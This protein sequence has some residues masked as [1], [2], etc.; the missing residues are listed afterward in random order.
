[1]IYVDTSTFKDAQQGS[2]NS[3]RP[4]VFTSTS[5]CRASGNFDIFSEN[6][7][8]LIYVNNFCNAGQVPIFR[9]FEACPSPVFQ[10]DLLIVARFQTVLCHTFNFAI[11]T[12]VV[13]SALNQISDTFIWLQT[14][15][16]YDS[17]ARL[18]AH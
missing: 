13:A 16:W 2:K 3:T 7:L 18:M 10:K 9:Y 15:D 17:E 14:I 4:L 12:H 1:M 5:G 8:F 11:K 6:Y